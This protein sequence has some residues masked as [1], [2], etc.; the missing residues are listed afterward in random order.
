MRDIPATQGD[1]ADVE[2]SA[3]QAQHRCTGWSA[4]SGPAAHA[5]VADNGALQKELE[6]TQKEIGEIASGEMDQG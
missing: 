6:Q 1:R 2:T 3:T 4:P 5:D